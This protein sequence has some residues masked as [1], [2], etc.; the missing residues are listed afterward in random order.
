MANGNDPNT[1][2]PNTAETNP[3]PPSGGGGGS[4]A[5]IALVAIVAVIAILFFTGVL[6]GGADAVGDET[7]VD[8][9]V[10]APEIPDVNIDVPEV[11]TSDLEVGDGE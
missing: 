3:P 6:G 9:D 7:S 11:D 1:V 4:T 5:I 8:V 2:N 10:E